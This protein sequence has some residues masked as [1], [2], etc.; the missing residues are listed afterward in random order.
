MTFK[1]F[2]HEFE[3]DDIQEWESHNEDSSHTITGI[4]P[5]TLC[6]F[7]TDFSFTGKVKAGKT[8]CI[9][10]ECKENL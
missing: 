4:A 5:C 10:E 2:D 9:C 7:S 6:G 1:C 3:C 8:P